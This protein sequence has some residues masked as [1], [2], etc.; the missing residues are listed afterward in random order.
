MLSLEI[1][2]L[3][4]LCLTKLNTL[5]PSYSHVS[6][7]KW[8]WFINF[9]LLALLNS[10][11]TSLLKCSICSVRL[12]IFLFNKGSK[13]LSTNYFAFSPSSPRE[14]FVYDSS[15]LYVIL[16]QNHNHC[17]WKDLY[18]V[19]DS[20]HFLIIL[21]PEAVF[22]FRTFKYLKWITDLI[23]QLLVSSNM[24]FYIICCLRHAIALVTCY[25][26]Q[27]LYIISMFIPSLFL[28]EDHITTATH[29]FNNS[30]YVDLPYYTSIHKFL[31]L[32]MNSFYWLINFHRVFLT[33]AC[34]KLSS[35]VSKLSA[36]L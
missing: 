28:V 7:W 29:I 17:I 10:F 36:C 26:F 31:G 8:L 15:L 23:F 25:Q 6:H 1:L 12:L 30:W 24:L 21:R 11:I 19:V 33:L 14:I 35:L 18:I 22:T 27:T 13:T 9:A 5:L 16:L 2:C 32:N 20:M 34:I 4:L 3:V